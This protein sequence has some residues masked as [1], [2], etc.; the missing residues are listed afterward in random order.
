MAVFQ[1]DP[2]VIIL[3]VGAVVFYDVLVVTEPQY[4]YLFLDGRDFRK[5]GG[6]QYL[7]RIEVASLLVQGLA[8]RAISALSEYV[9]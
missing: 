4:L 2:Q 8:D 3:E 6:R 5:T 9:Q 1:N 7:D